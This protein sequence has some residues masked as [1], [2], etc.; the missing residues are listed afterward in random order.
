MTVARKKPGK[1]GG[2][3]QPRKTAPDA[4]REP[5]LGA[6]P[7]RQVGSTAYLVVDAVAAEA[8]RVRPSGP[9]A[10]AASRIL[11]AEEPSD[12]C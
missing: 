6:P 10:V 9:R 3:A 7:H 8:K 5:A 2:G 12:P 11:G 1:R 4:A